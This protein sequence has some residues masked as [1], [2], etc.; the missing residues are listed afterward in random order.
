MMSDRSGAVGIATLVLALA[1]LTGCAEAP[2]EQRSPG[3]AVVDPDPPPTVGLD[4]AHLERAFATAAELPR[5]RCLLVARHGEILGE[6]CFRGGGPEAY[7]N[8][9][10]VSKSILSAVVGIA[11]AEGHLGGADQAISPF[12]PEYLGAGADA[13]ADITIEQL[14]TMQSGLIRTS[15]NEYGRWVQSPNWVRYVLTQPMSGTPGVERVYS[16]GNSHLLSAIL[17]RATGRSTWE[18]AR[19]KLAEPIGIQLPRWPTDP[20][21]IFFGGN[22]MR[23]TPRAMVRIG[24]LYRNGGVYE[25]RQVVP[26]EWVEAS[27]TPRSRSRAIGAGYGY[28]WFLG[29]FRGHPMFYASG[30]GGQ[31]IFVVPDLELTV[32]TTSDPDDART[33]GHNQSVQR[34]VRDILVPAAEIGA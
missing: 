26:R 21:G 23:I 17:T 20:Q 8:V 12:F 1:L 19:Q 9:K 6:R 33:P 31:Y 2:Q 15:G 22:E 16:T 14:L 34:L 27:L 3:A 28:G 30:Y 29:E 13:R 10:S 25:G 7:A 24:E 5:L 32:V 18:Y 4:S 11:I